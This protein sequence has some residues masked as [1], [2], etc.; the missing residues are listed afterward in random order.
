[1]MYNHSSGE[2]VKGWLPWHGDE[3]RVSEVY[4]EVTNFT[5]YE[6]VAGTWIFE[7]NVTLTDSIPENSYQFEVYFTNWTYGEDPDTPYGE[8]EVLTW[9]KELVYSFEDN[10]GHRIFVERPDKAYYVTDNRS[11]RYRI[12]ERPYIII[13]GEK[14]TIKPRE[15]WDPVTG[16]FYY[17]LLWWDHWDPELEEGIYYYLL[18]DGTKIFVYPGFAGY[19]YNW[20]FP[21][22]GINVLSPSKWLYSDYRTGKYYIFLLNGSVLS[23][24]EWPYYEEPVDLNV[25]IELEYAGWAILVNGSF[26]LRLQKPIQWDPEVGKHFIILE[27]GTEIYLEYWEDPYW[28]YYFER[29]G[30]IYFVD[31]SMKYFEG[32][33]D[34]DT[35]IIYDRDVQRY[36]YTEIGEERYILPAP[37]VRVYGWWDLNRPEPEGKVPVD[38]Y[39][40]YNGSLY[41]LMYDN[42]TGEDRLFIETENGTV[43]FKE[44]RMDNLTRAWWA[45]IRG[46]EYWLKHIGDRIPYGDFSDVQLQHFNIIGYLDIAL[47]GWTHNASYN[48]IDVY[49]VRLINSTIIYVNGTWF[50]W[51]FKLNY[52]GE[53]YYVKR[54]WPHYESYENDTKYIFELLNGSELE[55]VGRYKIIEAI[56]IRIGANETFTFNGET[57]NLSEDDWLTDYYY[58]IEKNGK[59]Y[60]VN[61]NGLWGVGIPKIFNVTYEGETYT[62]YGEPGWV[63]RKAKIWGRVYGWHHE[64]LKIGVFMRTHEL[65]VGEPEWGM[66]GFRAWTVDP[67]TGALDLDGDL[68]TTDDRFYVKRVYVGT[69]HFNFTANGMFVSLLWEPNVSQPFD[70]L[71]MNAWMGVSTH[72]WKYTWNETYYWYYAENMS[73]VSRETMDMIRSTILDEEGNPKPGY[74]EIAMMVENRSWEDILEMA[75]EKGW[76]WISDEYQSWTWIWFG[77]EQFYHASWHENNT[78]QWAYIALRYEYAGLYIFNDT[79]GDGIMN[80]NEITHYFMPNSV[81]NIT[82]MTPGEPFGNYNRTGEIIVPGDEEISFGI[83]YDSINGTTFPADHSIWWWYGGEALSG[84]DFNTFNTRPVDVS[85]DFMMFKLHFQGN[86]T[87]DE[88]GNREAYIKIDQYVGDWDVML[89]R[90]REVLENRS[91]SISYYV[92]LETSMHWSV[93]SE[94]GTPLTNEQVAEASRIRIG[95]EDVSF[96]EIVLGDQYLWGYNYTM[97]DATA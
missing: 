15:F 40:L 54:P 43:Y 75:R 56:R 70:E 60:I 17:D 6:D 73:S 45:L 72:Y 67:E 18:E 59:E 53:T 2:W 8:H 63:L 52:S 80:K 10:E 92:Y 89:S 19:V 83:I 64:R 11:R 94:E 44:R 93:Y 74:W 76:D 48:G 14:L 37:G 24:D 36:Y 97:H 47:G 78:D 90:G 26:I 66:W 29:N 91:L 88:L 3:T 21:D 4:L 34:G 87:A 5:R 23:F 65:I 35:V 96:A 77:F 1:Y 85:I 28:S 13:G 20:T 7:A 51:I 38:K 61:Y 95:A 12:E 27:N 86:L 55:I 71:N 25:T 49:K 81:E 68:S 39:V 33:Y 32:T 9:V 30:K 82:F 84:S 22:L 31:W 62:I 41:L 58:Y 79:D 46:H 69:Y 42:S 16:R 50:L 57:Y